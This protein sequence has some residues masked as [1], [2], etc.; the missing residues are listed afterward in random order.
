M[1]PQP[2]SPPEPK[3]FE[4]MTALAKQVMSVPKDE[5]DRREQEWRKDQKRR[6]RRKSSVS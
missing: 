5:I 1:E 6:P 4:R 3:P 2:S